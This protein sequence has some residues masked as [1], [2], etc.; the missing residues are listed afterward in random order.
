MGIGSKCITNM[1]LQT[2]YKLSNIITI[3]I[4]NIQAK[5]L[6]TLK[7]YDVNV[8]KFIRLA[9][10]EKIQRDWKTIKEKKTKFKTLI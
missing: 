8:N 9:I 10:K 6:E 7:N 4:N 5:S 2:D 3:R 1:G